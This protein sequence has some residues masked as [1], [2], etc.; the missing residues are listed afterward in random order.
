NVLAAE[1]RVRGS[2]QAL[3]PATK[4][5]T[6]WPLGM[7]ANLA[8][9]KVMRNDQVADLGSNRPAWKALGKLVNNYDGRTPMAALK[10]DNEDSSVYKAISDLRTFL[11]PLGISIPHGRYLLEEIPPEP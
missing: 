3:P 11:R 4:F 2:S 5:E 10:G 6:D 1:N 7:R 8:E 9:Q